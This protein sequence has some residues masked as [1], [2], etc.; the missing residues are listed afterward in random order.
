MKIVSNLIKHYDEDRYWRSREYVVQKGGNKLLKILRLLYLRRCDALNGASM[1]THLGGGATF[2][3]PP[4]LPHGLKGIVISHFAKFG[5]GVRIFHQ[6]T[7]GNDDRDIENAPEIGD[8]VTIFPGAKIVGKIKIGNNVT[9]GPNAVVF[10]DV[11]DN[12]TVIVERPKV[13]IK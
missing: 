12:A 10:F 4:H 11:P 9:I 1:G 2:A 8:N 3:E 7:I 6:V 5:R 13:I